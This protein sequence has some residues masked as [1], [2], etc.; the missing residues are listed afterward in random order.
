MG[1]VLQNGEQGGVVLVCEHRSVLRIKTAT[2]DTLGSEQQREV[3]QEAGWSGVGRGRSEVE[4][5]QNRLRFL[6]IVANSDFLLL[7]AHFVE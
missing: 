6:L 7:F 3:L 4:T 5:E 2:E 1:C